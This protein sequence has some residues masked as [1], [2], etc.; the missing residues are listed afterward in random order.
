MAQC[1]MGDKSDTTRNKCNNCG[2]HVCKSHAQSLD[3]VWI[4]SRHKCPVCKQ[5]GISG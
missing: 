5:P 2:T 3:Y 4:E 1:Y